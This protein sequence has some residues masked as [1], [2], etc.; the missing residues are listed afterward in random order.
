VIDSRPV[1]VQG[2]ENGKVLLATILDG[3]VCRPEIPLLDQKG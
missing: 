2:D 1:M 3:S